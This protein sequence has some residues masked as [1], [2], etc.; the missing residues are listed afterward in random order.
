MKIEMQDE[1]K[2]V[3]L[4]AALVAGYLSYGICVTDLE[5]P[6]GINAKRLVNMAENILREIKSR[7]PESDF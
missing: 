7:A 1:E 5:K 3:T 4:T 2:L 6:G